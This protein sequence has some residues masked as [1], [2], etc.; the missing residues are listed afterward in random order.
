VKIFWKAWK[1]NQFFI[2]VRE[3]K[4]LNLVTRFSKNLGMRLVSKKQ[5]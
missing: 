2:P 5:L 1:K 4:I 3:V